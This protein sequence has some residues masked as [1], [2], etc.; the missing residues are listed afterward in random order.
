VAFDQRFLLVCTA[1]TKS[2]TTSSFACVPTPMMKSMVCTLVPLVDAGDMGREV[3]RGKVVPGRILLHARL[4]VGQHLHRQ[5]RAGS[6]DRGRDL[7]HF[8]RRPLEKNRSIL[9]DLKSSEARITFT[10][11]TFCTSFMVDAAAGEQ[12]VQMGDDAVCCTQSEG[13]CLP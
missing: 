9:P 2:R 4:G 1:L 12:R 3:D 8:R 6:A 7:L 13:T 5:D 11:G 10:V